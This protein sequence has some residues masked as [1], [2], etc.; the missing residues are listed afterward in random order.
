MISKNEE[1][2][3]YLGSW[4][5]LVYPNCLETIKPSGQLVINSIVGKLRCDFIKIS[6]IWESW[7]AVGVHP[8]LMSGGAAHRQHPGLVQN[9][10]EQEGTLTRCCCCSVAQSCPTLQL[11]GLQHAKLPCPSLYPGVCSNSCPLSR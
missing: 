8:G 7:G 3:F 6:H 2:L 11:Q 1:L 4:V 10:R 9:S 5:S